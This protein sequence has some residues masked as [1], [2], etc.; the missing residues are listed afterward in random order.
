[1]N[2]YPQSLLSRTIF[3]IMLILVIS[4]F[5]SNMLVH[6]LILKPR[7]QQ[8]VMTFGE[9]LQSIHSALLA[10]PDRQRFIFVKYLANKQHF[11]VTNDHERI[12]KLPRLVE[13]PKFRDLLSNYLPTP[14]GEKQLDIRY[15]KSDEHRY[16]VNLPVAEHNYWIGFSASRLRS[17]F[18]KELIIWLSCTLVFTL[19]G[20]YW[21][22]S[23]INRS[24][25][26]LSTAARRIGQGEQIENLPEQGALEIRL[27]TRAF[28]KMHHDIELLTRNRTLLLAGVSHDLR[29]PLARM[30]LNLEMI[31]A[32]NLAQTRDELI[33]DI[34]DMDNILEQFLVFVREGGEETPAKMDLNALI[35]TVVE[36]YNHSEILFQLDLAAALPK[37]M[38]QP[39][40]IQRVLINLIDNASKYAPGSPISITSRLRDDKVEIVVSDHGSG[41]P[42]H[43]RNRLLEPFTQL[44]EGRK[45]AGGTGLGLAIA[46][47][48]VESHLG[49][50]RL[51]DTV[52]GG[53]LVVVELPWR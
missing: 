7:A 48:I 1:M 6:H 43:E 18:P 49:V 32:S 15:E 19:V 38:L 23:R 41:I 11:A 27:L 40:A 13:Y 4:Q 14:P 51:E 33:Q 20:S 44:N 21:L 46:K 16:W 28:N 36:R 35:T 22:V 24:L 17:S 3:I 2:L 29:T 26:V 53:L 10:L 42:T 39:I 5:L 50:I 8:R 30:R 52:G 37:V 47:R 12:L 25:K 9:N 34:E 31:K 45:S